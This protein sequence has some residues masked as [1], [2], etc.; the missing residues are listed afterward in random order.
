MSTHSFTHAKGTIQL[1]IG[2]VAL[3]SPDFQKI[4]TC[5]RP[6]PS[7]ADDKWTVFSA[8]IFMADNGRV[9]NLLI[10]LKGLVDDI[11]RNNNEPSTT[12]FTSDILD[13]ATELA[14]DLVVM[15]MQGCDADETIIQG[16]QKYVYFIQLSRHGR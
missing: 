5:L 3:E 2:F 7:S 11:R 1:R 16:V 10:S 12:V 15:P 6:G 4:F 8:A 13:E 14:R 9:N